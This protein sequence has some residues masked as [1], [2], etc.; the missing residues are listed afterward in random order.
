MV[1]LE[2]FV[3]VMLRTIFDA[4]ARVVCRV[5]ENIAAVAVRAVFGAVSGAAA[6]QSGVAIQT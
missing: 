3:A 1:T 4:L 5:E 6:T 2:A